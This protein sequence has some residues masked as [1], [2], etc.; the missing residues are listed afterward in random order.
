MFKRSAISRPRDITLGPDGALWFTNQG[1]L[2][3]PKLHKNP[4]GRITTTGGVRSYPARG[5]KV[6]FAI[7]TGRGKTL[8]F[9]SSNAHTIGAI[10][11]GGT[12]TTRT[13]ATTPLGI[14]RAP[15]GE[16]WFTTGA[17]GRSIG[18]MSA[19]GQIRRYTDPRPDAIDFPYAIT[20]GPDGALWFT[21]NNSIG[22]ISTDGDIRIY[23]APGLDFPW[24]ITTGPDGALWFTD[25][26][27]DAIGRISTDGAIRTFTDPAIDGPSG[28]TAGPDGALWFTTN[29]AALFSSN[30]SIGRISTDGHIRTFTDPGI[31]GPVAIAAGSD[32]ALWFTNASR[33]DSIGRITTDGRIRIFTDP[34]LEQP[35]AIAADPTAPCGSRTRVTST[36]AQGRS[37]GSA[38]TAT[39]AATPAPA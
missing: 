7:T 16:L 3:F 21:N 4:I 23:T 19:D 35:V 6:A 33:L 31:R 34:S 9:T 14:A 5:L 10:T 8:S 20:A 17:R 2:M 12:V 13:V 25:A 29:D 32:G 1:S 15:D 38:W 27:A 24:M 28:I 37:D 39:S 11:T 18:R 36:T 26:D 30:D 22:R